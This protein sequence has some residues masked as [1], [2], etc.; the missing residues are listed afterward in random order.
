MKVLVAVDKNLESFIGLR[1]ACHLLRNTGSK[2]HALHVTPGVSDIDSLSYA[3]FLT[4]DGFKEAIDTE[5]QQVENYFRDESQSCLDSEV[6]CSLHVAEGDPADEIL[7]MAQT[8]GY[9]MVVLGSHEESF[10]RGLFLGAVHA[11]ILHHASQPVLIVRRFREI[12]TVLVVCRGSKTDVAALKFITPLLTQKRAQITLLHVQETGSSENDEFARSSL[13]HA[14]Q[15]LRDVDLE[16]LTKISKGDFVEEILKDV[17]INRY[18]L[19][20]LGAHGHNRPRYLDLISDEALNLAR[21]TTRPIL[22]YRDK[23]TPE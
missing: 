19:V 10:V 16:P 4:K 8:D 17:A 20:V 1:Y 5:I 11:K 21:L 7:N 2:L 14:S 18:D 15:I 12:H 13:Q 3:P 23:T 22:V 6:A 9:D